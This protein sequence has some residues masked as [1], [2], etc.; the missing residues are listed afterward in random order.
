MRQGDPASDLLFN[1]YIDE[2]KNFF[3]KNRISKLFLKETPIYVI[4][5]ADV[6]LSA[7]SPPELQISQNWLAEYVRE[8]V[9]T[10]NVQKCYCIA[11]TRAQKKIYLKINVNDGILPQTHE[12]NYQKFLFNNKLNLK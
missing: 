9:L 8:N 10:I 4:K 1:L 11:V 3:F 2:V 7:D 12:L 5:Y 6:V